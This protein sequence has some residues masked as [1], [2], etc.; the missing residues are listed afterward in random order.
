MTRVTGRNRNPNPSYERREIVRAFSMIGP[1]MNPRTSGGRGQPE[2]CIAIPSVPM[3]ISRY[4]SPILLP[5]IHAP[6]R[7]NSTTAGTIRWPLINVARAICFAPTISSA[8][9]ITLA[10]IRVAT[11]EK[12]MSS[13]EVSISGPGV[14]P[15]IRKAPS[16]IAIGALPGMPKATV[17]TSAPPFMALLAVSGAITPRTSPLPNCDLSRALWTAWP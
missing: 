4:Q 12:V 17:G 14:I 3:P 6:I 16:R 11:I 5:L 10:T 8:A 2:N 13:F 7:T 9:P 1:R 15:W